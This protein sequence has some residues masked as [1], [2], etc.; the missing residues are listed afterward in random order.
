MCMRVFVLVNASRLGI[1]SIKLKHLCPCWPRLL[2]ALTRTMATLEVYMGDEC[3]NDGR[4]DS[5][6]SGDDDN[7][8]L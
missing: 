7:K 6:D 2:A 5:D 4:G 1:S 3:D 8:L